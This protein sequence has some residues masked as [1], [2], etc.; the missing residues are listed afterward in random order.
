M[1]RGGFC[2]LCPCHMPGCGRAGR[3]GTA[4][5]GA[6]LVPAVPKGMEDALTASSAT[7]LGRREA[8][9]LHLSFG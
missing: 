6:E 1:P 4:P 5:P 9:L 8:K 2:R 7:G 3:M